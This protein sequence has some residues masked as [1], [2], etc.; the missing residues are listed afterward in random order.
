MG[1]LPPNR[2]EWQILDALWRLG[3]ATAEEVFARCDFRPPLG[4]DAAQV[5]LDGLISKGMIARATRDQRLV[6]MPAVTR[7]QAAR[8]AVQQIL[9]GNLS[10]SLREMLSGCL[11]AIDESELEKLERLVDLYRKRQI[12][13]E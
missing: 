12:N 4:N 3:E 6:F 5:L 2:N 9:E 8:I 11:V 13:M 1:H 10:G 7:E